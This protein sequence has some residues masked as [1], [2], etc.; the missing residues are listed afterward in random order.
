MRFFFDYVTDGQTLYDYLGGEFPSPEL[1]FDFAEAT[2]QDLKNSGNG[3]WKGWSVEVRNAEC[4]KFF[5]LPVDDRPQVKPSG[6][7]A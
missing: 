1:A 6:D 3:D 2:T 4:K 5:S 7:A